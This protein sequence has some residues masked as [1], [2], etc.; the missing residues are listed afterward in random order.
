M[1]RNLAQGKTVRQ[2]SIVEA[3][4]ELHMSRRLALPVI[5]ANIM[6]VKW[7]YLLNERYFSAG[8]VNLSHGELEN[9]V[10]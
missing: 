9:H 1:E 8:V 7:P 5:W 10:C 2:R 4:R 3:S 6:V